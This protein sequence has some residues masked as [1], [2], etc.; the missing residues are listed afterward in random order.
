MKYRVATTGDEAS[1]RTHYESLKADVAMIQSQS[2]IGVEL[3]Q[4]KSV[5]PSYNPELLRLSGRSFI[6]HDTYILIAAECGL[7]RWRLSWP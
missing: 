2:L 3:Q 5:A 7:P 4:F 1:S 6:A